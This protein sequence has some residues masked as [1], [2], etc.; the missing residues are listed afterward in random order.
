MIPVSPQHVTPELRALF[1]ADAPASLRCFAVLD[2]NAAGVVWTDDP[3]HPTWGIVQEAGFRSVYLGGRH[4]IHTRTSL[5]AELRQ[6]GEVLIGLSH[7]DQRFEMLPPNPDYVGTTLE[8][9]NRPMG[10]GLD[11]FLRQTPEGC[12]LHRVDR[13]LFERCLERELLIRI[14][15]SVEK[16]LENGFGLCLMRDDQILSE[17]HAGPAAHGLIEIGSMTP[18]RHRYRGY[19][20]L[21]CAH[22]I[23]TCEELGFQT[24]WNCAK[25][26]QASVAL[27][28]KLGYRTM[29][30]YEL[31]AWFGSG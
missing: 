14:F 8:F 9:T 18:E 23:H 1:D 15:G 17:A 4:D 30:E 29:K 27:A 24:Y 11:V 16:A 26:N 2:G 28:R 13:G 7:E 22:L 19:A 25:Q 12:Q 31:R 10:K 20:T 21:T 3:A 5:F 6:T